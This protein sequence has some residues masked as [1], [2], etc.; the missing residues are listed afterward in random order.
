MPNRAVAALCLMPCCRMLIRCAARAVLCSLD[1]DFDYDN[2]QLTRRFW[3]P[4]RPVPHPRSDGPV[5][6]LH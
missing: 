3:P 5:L 2:V 4:Q 1:P 6:P